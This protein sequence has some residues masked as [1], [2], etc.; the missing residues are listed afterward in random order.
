MKFK[1]RIISTEEI[2]M[3]DLAKIRYEARCYISQNLQEVVCGDIDRHST[4][5]RVLLINY[6]FGPASNRGEVFLVE[7]THRTTPEAGV[8]RITIYHA[9]APPELF[10]DNLA[11]IVNKKVEVPQ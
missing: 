11:E 8:Y 1:K 10:I 7:E 6:H 3:K 9:D 2:D 5:P 4:N